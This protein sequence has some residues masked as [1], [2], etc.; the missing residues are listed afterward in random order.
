M[1]VF[2]YEKCEMCAH[3]KK[4]SSVILFPNADSFEVTVGQFLSH[5]SSWAYFIAMSQTP[6]SLPQHFTTVPPPSLCPFSSNSFWQFPKTSQVREIS[7]TIRNTHEDYGIPKVLKGPSS[8]RGPV[9]WAER[10]CEAQWAECLCEHP[11][12]AHALWEMSITARSFKKKKNKQTR[13]QKRTTVFLYHGCAFFVCR[14]CV[15]T[16]ALSF[17]SEDIFISRLEGRS[18]LRF[19]E[20]PNPFLLYH[21]KTRRGYSVP[22]Q[23]LGTVIFLNIIF[24]MGARQSCEEHRE[25]RDLNSRPT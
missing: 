13:R 4:Q 11:E 25:P 18:G 6:L 16:R 21:L 22:E 24:F 3:L 14:E 17:F 19:S 8:G 10:L 12:R 20:R 2:T 5:A 15:Y 23:T 9:A 1:P 7:L